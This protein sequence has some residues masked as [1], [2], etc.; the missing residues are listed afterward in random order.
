MALSGELEHLEPV[1]A[2]I[3]DLVEAVYDKT[4]EKEGD[5]ARVR[6]AV[7][8]IA[9]CAFGDAVVGTPLRGMLDYGDDA[10]RDI[11]VGLL[12]AFFAWPP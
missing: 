8:I 9:L 3:L 2:A 1:R 6:R 7:L 11:V 5:R 12:P 10:A 4:A